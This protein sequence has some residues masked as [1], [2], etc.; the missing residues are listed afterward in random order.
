MKQLVFLFA[1]LYSLNSFGAKTYTTTIH[2]TDGYSNISLGGCNVKITSEEGDLLFEGITNTS[3]FLTITDM[4]IKEYFIELSEP[5]GNFYQKKWKHL[6]KKKNDE[7]IK[8]ILIPTP[9]YE[10]EMFAIEDS[11]YGD[12]EIEIYDSLDIDAEFPGGIAELQ[13]YINSH[14]RYPEESIDLKE[15]GKVY[16]EFIVETDGSVSHVVVVKGVSKNL[17]NEAKRVIRTMP[18]WTPGVLNTVKV[19]ARFRMPIVFALG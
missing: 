3:G 11:I 15:Q 5:N 1:F 16:L 8:H 18:I 17:D 13:R 4:A 9:K 2:V 6:N 19:R 14:V 10:L 7:V 12:V